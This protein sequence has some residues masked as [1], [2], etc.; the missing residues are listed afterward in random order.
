MARMSI[1]D[2][3]QRDPRITKLAGLVGWSCHRTTEALNRA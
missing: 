2:I 1:D 3:V